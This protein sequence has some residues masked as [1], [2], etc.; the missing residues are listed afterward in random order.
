MHEYVIAVPKSIVWKLPKRV[1]SRWQFRLAY[2]EE[3]EDTGR[4]RRLGGIFSLN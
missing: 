1:L 4:E 3:E 2:K